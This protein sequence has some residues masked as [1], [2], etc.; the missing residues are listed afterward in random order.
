MICMQ[1]NAK[2]TTINYNNKFAITVP[3]ILEIMLLV[4][5]NKQQ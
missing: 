1:I 2:M 3:T 4:L 5:L